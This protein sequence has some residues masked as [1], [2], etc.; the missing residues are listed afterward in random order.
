M[1]NFIIMRMLSPFV[2]QAPA[3]GA[4]PFY[5][6]HHATEPTRSASPTDTQRIPQTGDYLLAQMG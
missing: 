4:N 6:E 5:R 2:C 3:A 1:V